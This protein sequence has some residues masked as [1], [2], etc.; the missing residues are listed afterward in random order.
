VTQETETGFGSGLRAELLR[1]LGGEEEHEAPEAEIEPTTIAA[2][3]AVEEL[4]PSALPDEDPAVSALREDLEAALHRELQLREALQ[5]QVEAYERELDADRDFALREAEFEQR[6]ARLETARTELEERDLVLRIQRDQIEAEHAELAASRTEIVAEEARVAELATH[7]DARSQLLESTGKDRAQASA[8]LAQ[9]LAAIAERERELKRERAALD[10]HRQNVDAR[11][12]ASEQRVRDLQLEYVRREAALAS[13]ELAA[14]A[15]ATEND[16]SSARL[17]ER[18]E[19]VVTREAVADKRNDAR[20][21]MLR[22]GE[23]ALAAREKRLREQGELLE[24]ERAGHGQASQEAF[25]LLAE[26]EQREARVS[27]RETVLLEGEA[28]LG[29]RTAEL[30]RGE[31]ELRMRSARLGAD[32]DLREDRLEAREQAV[33]QR[34]HLISDR[35]RDLTQYVGE[36]Q[37]QFSEPGQFS[38]RSVA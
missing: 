27:E 13:R 28:K 33:A 9:Q 18:I 2:Q 16:R 21:Q 15:Q 34:E 5:H 23:A 32:L 8:H 35:E 26:L 4:F 12:A 10:T 25:A 19:A 31:E 38:E 17:E 37:G 36:L 1:K 14:Q 3:P 30:A 22:N 24:R 6:A 11:C 20:D 29:E 7:V